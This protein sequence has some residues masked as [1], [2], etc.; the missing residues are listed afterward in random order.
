M[1]GYSYYTRL[2]HSVKTFNPKFTLAGPFKGDS[3]FTR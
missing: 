1:S 3:H 2:S